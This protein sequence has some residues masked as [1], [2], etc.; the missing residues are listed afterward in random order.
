ME[1]F[2]AQF[3]IW[4]RALS[5][6]RALLLLAMIVGSAC[7]DTPL[8]STGKIVQLNLMTVPIALDFDDRAGPEGISVKVYASASD[9]P[10]PVRLREGTLELL[11]FDGPFQRQAPPP[12]VLRRF[13]YSVP[14]LLP[15]EFTARLGVG[16]QFNLA[17]GTNLPT[18]RIMSVAARYTSGQGQV[19]LSRPNSVTVGS[20]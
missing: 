2:F 20:Y 15:H 7:K 5:R 16:Y 6:R 18:Q 1:K 14:E 4:R 10:K 3:D 11:L 19:V 13:Q 8:R 9:A 12:P 17:W